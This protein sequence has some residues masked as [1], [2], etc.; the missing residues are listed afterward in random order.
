MLFVLFI[1]GT[2]TLAK[3]FHTGITYIYQ[4]KLH[5]MVTILDFLLFFK[6]LYYILFIIFNVDNP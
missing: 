4:F 6:A 3:F 1:N 5:L 2:D